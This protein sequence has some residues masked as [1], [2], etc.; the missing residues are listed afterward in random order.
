VSSAGGRAARWRRDGKELFY[1]SIADELMAVDVRS[2][3][4]GLEFS[5]PRRLFQAH[6]MWQGWSPYVVSPDGQT[7]RIYS[8]PEETPARIVLIQNWTALLP[9]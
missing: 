9:R 8:L 4:D 5:T 3:G 6:P 2:A 7:F 1:L